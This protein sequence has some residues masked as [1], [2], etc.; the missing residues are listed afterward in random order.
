VLAFPTGT[1]GAL[2]WIPRQN[3]QG[4]GDYNSYVGGYGTFQFLGYTFAV[5]GYASRQDTSA[6]NGDAQDVT[7]EFEV[8]LD[9]SYNKAPLNYTTGRTDSVVIQFGQ[10]AA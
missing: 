5:H 1:V 3:R 10:L 9:S 4:W 2:N 8:S 7:M 6:T